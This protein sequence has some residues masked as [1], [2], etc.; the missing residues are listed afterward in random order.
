MTY[1]D[2]VKTTDLSN[3][4]PL[5][6]IFG[7]LEEAGEIAGI[8]KRCMRGDYGGMVKNFA[9]KGEW[10]EVFY[11]DEVVND[12]IKETGDKHWYG[13]RLLQEMGLDWQIIETVNTAKLTKRK[14]VEKIMGKGDNREV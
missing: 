6:Y 7:M 1:E 5:F 3:H 10:K 11:N 14:E 4:S 13:T 2:F 12:L 9:E 8:C